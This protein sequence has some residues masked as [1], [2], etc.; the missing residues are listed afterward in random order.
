MLPSTSSAWGRK[1]SPSSVNETLRVPRKERRKFRAM[2]HNCQKHGV[3]SQA[4]GRPYFASYL[5]GFASYI[6]MVHPEE[7][8]AL[9]AEVEALLAKERAAE[10]QA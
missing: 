1:A 3:A 4:R 8:K 6:H 2:V 5:Q 7:G 10:D 9:M